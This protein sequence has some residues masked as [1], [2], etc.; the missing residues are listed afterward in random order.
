MARP[1]K[2][3]RPSIPFKPEYPEKLI[4][5]MAQGL[6]FESFGGVVGVSRETLYAWNKRHKAFADAKKEG[7]AKSRYLWEKIGI[8]AMLGIE[9]DIGGQKVKGSN[10]N[11]GMWIFNMK[12]RFGWRDKNE[13]DITTA[14][15]PIRQTIKIGGKEIEF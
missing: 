9:A 15:Q 6:S 10:F 7:E 3:G 12:N 4:N 11:T 1:K 14:G 13:T 5:H 8:A 2:M